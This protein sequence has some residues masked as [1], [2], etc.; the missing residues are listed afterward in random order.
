M[1]TNYEPNT[2]GSL[3]YS[4]ARKCC[5]GFPLSCKFP[6][7]ELKLQGCINFA[8]ILQTSLENLLHAELGSVATPS[9]FD[10][11][12]FHLPEQL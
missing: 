7:V 9:N 8:F 12:P 2:M 5:C 10:T 11:V 6:Y 1:H 4:R 3:G